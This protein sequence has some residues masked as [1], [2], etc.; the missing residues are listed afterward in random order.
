MRLFGYARVSTSQQCLDIQRNALIQYGVDPKRIFSDKATGSNTE[1]DGLN[2]LK[3]K[4]EEGDIIIVKSLD[5]LGRNTCDMANLVEEFNNAGVH[6]R[7]LDNGI[8]TEGPTGKMIIMIL[9]AIAEAERKR[10]IERT[11]EGRIE[12]QAKGIKF[13][14]KRTVNRQKMEELLS[15]GMKPK[16]VAE[17]LNIG[18]S[19]VYSYRPRAVEKIESW[20][21][22]QKI[23]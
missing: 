17:K 22:A 2:L 21:P 13:G 10:I 3:L 20:H 23:G 15:S 19:T 16:D 14:R 11:E 4:L 6:I 5:R 8:T 9:A 18:Y 1:R 7:F 12:A